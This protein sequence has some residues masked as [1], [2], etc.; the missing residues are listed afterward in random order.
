MRFVKGALVPMNAQAMSKIPGTLVIKVR[1]TCIPY[2]SA[3]RQLLR[4]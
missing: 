2:F 1:T 3:I 4:A